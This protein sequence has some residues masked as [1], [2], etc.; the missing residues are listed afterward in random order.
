MDYRYVSIP[1]IKRELRERPDDFTVWFKIIM[2][3]I[4][5]Y[6]GALQKVIVC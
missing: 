3:E 5:P 6:L 4:D 1:N 2:D